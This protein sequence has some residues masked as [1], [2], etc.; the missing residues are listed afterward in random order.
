MGFNFGTITSGLKDFGHSIA[1]IVSPFKKVA[2]AVASPI[3]ASFQSIGGITGNIFKV[4][5]NLG[6]TAVSLTSG[7]MLIYLGLGCGAIALIYVIK[8]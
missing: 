4:G 7:N 2:N 5:E 1:P 8:K 6:K 3:M